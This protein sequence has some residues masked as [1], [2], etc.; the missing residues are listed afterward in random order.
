MATIPGKKYTPK[1]KSSSATGWV[2]FILLLLLAGGGGYYC[3]QIKKQAEQE[4]RQLK[5][6]QQK[7]ARRLA[8]ARAEQEKRRRAEEQA[9]RE[10]E[11]AERRRLAEEEAERQRKAAEEQ[12]RLRQL[13]QQQQAEKPEPTPEK[14]TEEKPPVEEPEQH[15]F[16]AQSVLLMGG[17]SASTENRR[18][19]D[20][21]IEHV[22]KER[23]FDAFSTA[24]SEK[25]KACVPELINGDKLSY[26]AYKRNKILMQS[27]EFCLLIDMAGSDQLRT[28]F[29]LVGKRENRNGPDA[30][31]EFFLWMLRDKAQPLHR[32]MEAFVANEAVPDH[33][34]F[35]LAT[36]FEL[37]DET[38]EK[39]R[40]KYLNLAIACALMPPDITRDPGRVR[41][42]K[43]PLLS[44]KEVYNYFREMD[45][46]KK[47]LTDIKTLG[48]TPLLYIVDVRLPRSEFDWVQDKLH[49][50]QENW[51]NS[52][53]SI[54]YRMD[55]ATQ[56]KDL[57]HHYTFAE[58]R[59]E[60]GICM[61]QAYF[62]AMTA[63]CKG[64]PAVYITGDGDRGPH[65]WIASLID[66]VTWQQTGSYGYNTG[67][68][69]NRCSGRLH[70]ESLLLNQTK[71]TTDDKL[72]PAYDG[73][74]LSEYLVRH[75][76]VQEAR[77]TARY[78]TAA[79]PLMTAAW[80]NRI[81]VLAH[82]QE[83]LP[84]TAVWKGVYNDLMRHGR[85]NGELIDL[86]STV[87]DTYLTSGKSLSAQK[88]E[89]RRSLKRLQRAVGNERSDLI[90]EAI[91]RQAELLVENKDWRGL[92][93]LYKKALKDNTNRGDIFQQLLHQYMNYL[94]EDDKSAWKTLC[95]D[96]ES[97]FNKG[98]LTET[99]DYFKLSK[100][101]AIQKLIGEAYLKAGD[102]KKSQKLIE[103]AEERLQKSKSA[104]SD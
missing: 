90:V 18:K 101:V 35:S 14:D 98:V 2:T 16:Y 12:E 67:R 28:L 48:V 40:A 83:N 3:Y 25:I 54:R 33:I 100:E 88:G 84:D 41:N 103:S 97:I 46:Q 52:Y 9:A 81:Q 82:D 39:D 20:A 66:K 87:Q 31:K 21:M 43:T 8:K 68:F 32:F 38:P 4:A 55:R 45:A 23:D 5:I 104:F 74:V 102:S 36:L 59:K 79:F 95:K 13:Q 65:A 96:A 26:P 49:Y 73:M 93:A 91:D 58:L 85:K 11:E 57:Y 70:H 6:E 10:R 61:D 60:G 69:R 62:A 80:S 29:S 89:M 1:R 64:I 27:V 42:P 50:K 47:L 17:E 44:L 19:Y 94:P 7:E 99:G 86:A 37:W 75:H 63:K 71:K 51:G 22:L 92:A 34:N 53:A 78:V 76:C 77:S 24:F 56:H 30:G 15:S 72:A